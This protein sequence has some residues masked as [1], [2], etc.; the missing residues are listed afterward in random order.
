MPA[1][2]G[3]ILLMMGALALYLLW[4]SK[5]PFN[6]PTTIGG[7]N[8]P[9]TTSPDDVAGPTDPSKWVPPGPGATLL[10][11]GASLLYAVWSMPNGAI[12]YADPQGHVTGVERYGSAVNPSGGK[13]NQR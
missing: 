8:L 2:Q 5:S 6:K 11:L 4:H 7:G 1:A 3:V 13:G 10:H 12:L 9:P